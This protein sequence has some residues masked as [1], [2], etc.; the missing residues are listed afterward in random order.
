MIRTQ[1]RYGNVSRSIP[2]Q[3]VGDRACSWSGKS[4]SKIAF[5]IVSKG[6]RRRLQEAVMTGGR[7]R[8]FRFGDNAELLARI[9]LSHISFASPVPRQ[10]DIGHDFFCSLIERDKDLLRSSHFF[11]IQVKANKRSIHF[12]KPHEI[13]WLAQQQNPFFIAH[14]DSKKGKLDIYSTLQVVL[15]FL[16]GAAS[17]KSVRVYL[18]Q[19]PKNKR[20]TKYRDHEIIIDGSLCQIYLGKPIV[21]LCMSDLSD[22]DLT[23]HRVRVLS[24]WIKITRQNLTNSS[25][26]IYWCAVPQGWHTNE[27]PVKGR[28][29]FYWNKK[30]RQTSRKILF[31][32]A[33]Q[34]LL[35]IDQMLPLFEA[36]GT[37]LNLMNSLTNLLRDHKMIVEDDV[38]GVLANTVGFD[39][40]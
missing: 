34:I 39:W 5:G 36:K 40:T 37:D 18:K 22:E 10:E 26:G 24:D 3:A 8:L 32:A 27:L 7:N 6:R 33:A 25:T 19:I 30:N 11:T 31:R 28:I 17:E 29:Q 16:S 38:K 20:G 14:A 1:G 12:Q 9:I 35:E 13:V 2:Q 21:S 23:L 4:Y 15:A